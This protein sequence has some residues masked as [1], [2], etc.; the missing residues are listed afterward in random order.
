LTG[1]RSSMPRLKRLLHLRLRLL[2]L[3]LRLLH[4]RLRLLHLRLRMYVRLQLLQRLQ[5]SMQR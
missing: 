2:H 3:R 4:L 5:H 1:K